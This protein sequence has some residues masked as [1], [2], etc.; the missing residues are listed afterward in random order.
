MRRVAGSVVLAL[1][2]LLV[3]AAA[4][5]CPTCVS[6]AF[7]DR[8]YNWAYLGLLVMP[9]LLTAVVGAIVAWSAGVRLRRPAWLLAS[10]FSR[11]AGDAPAAEASRTPAKETT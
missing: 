2:A 7:G 4:L 3:P 10:Q 1:G 5:A 11:R 8:T 9:F 6:S